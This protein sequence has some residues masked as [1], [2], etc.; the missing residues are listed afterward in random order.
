MSLGYSGHH[1][2]MV[3]CPLLTQ[4]GRRSSFCRKPVHFDEGPHFV[5]RDLEETIQMMGGK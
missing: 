5:L 3:K 1:P 4:S 2:Q